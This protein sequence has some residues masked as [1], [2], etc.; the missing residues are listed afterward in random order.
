MHRNLSRHDSYDSHLSSDSF[1]LETIHFPRSLRWKEENTRLIR[2]DSLRDS[3]HYH[4]ASV[5]H[6]SSVL[7]IN[8]GG[9]FDLLAVTCF[10]SSVD[11]E[12]GCCLYLVS[13][14]RTACL[15]SVQRTSESSVL[16]CIRE[17]SDCVS[18]DEMCVSTNSDARRW[19][20]EHFSDEIWETEKVNVGSTAEFILIATAWER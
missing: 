5:T 3:H 12:F 6:L 1:P 18:L 2:P 13:T 4:E 10:R 8:F 14:L 11:Y 9:W 15:S 19:A 7:S 20:F 17:R 16:S